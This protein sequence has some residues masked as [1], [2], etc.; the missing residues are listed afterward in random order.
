MSDKDDAH[1]IRLRETVE[2]NI[3]NPSDYVAQGAAE[4]RARIVAWLRRTI[5]AE[6][7]EGTATMQACWEA[8]H[9]AANAIEDG[10]HLK[11]DE[12]GAREGVW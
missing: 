7:T 4:E 2:M 6:R 12:P 1:E 5:D 9:N 10:D 8:I 3:R 11:S